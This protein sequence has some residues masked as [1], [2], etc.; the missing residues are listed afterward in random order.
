VPT[1]P[2]SFGQ[3]E[4]IGRF[5]AE[6]RIPCAAAFAAIVEH[7]CLM[8]Y[9]V[10][11]DDMMGRAADFVARILQGAKPGDLPMEQPKTFELVIN[12]KTARALGL[13]I[14]Q[15]ILLRAD[16]VIE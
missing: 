13:T 5:V 10:N 14:P 7:G 15:T 8:S 1:G 4:R 9:G 12:M 6:K 16:R 11:N 3:R 2:V